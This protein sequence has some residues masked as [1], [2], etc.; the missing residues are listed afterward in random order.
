MYD[1][2]EP[3]GTIVSIHGGYWRDTY[4]VELNEPMV[5]HLVATGWRVANV[6][7]RRVSPADDPVWEDMSRDILRALE[8]TARSGPTVLLG[9][10]AGG[11]LALWAAAQA[12]TNIDGVVA[13]APVADLF[14]TDG[15]GLSKS[16]THQ[17]FGASAA[18]R[19]D[20]YLLAS[21]L[22][23]LPLGIPQLV[24]HGRSDEDVPFDMSA[25]YVETA[26]ALE[27]DITFVD[28]TGVDHF[29][30]IDPGHTV[31]RDI[32]HWLQGLQTP[33]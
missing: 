1:V 21:P 24:V 26:C 22:H 30:I 33:K 13:L 32:D 27:D 15:L 11:Q 2:D 12:D 29:D 17:L 20:V 7:Y 23:L 6:E 9:H 8:T 3:L 10:S 14:L 19:P 18:E 25:E 5:H 28:P 31:W 4:G 16:A